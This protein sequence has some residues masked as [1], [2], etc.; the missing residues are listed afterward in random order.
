MV[1]EKRAHHI[2]EEAGAAI[3]GL[4]SNPQCVVERQHCTNDGRQL[5]SLLVCP[6]G[7]DIA[8]KTCITTCTI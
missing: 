4:L 2:R 5:H 8:R 7:G 6:W 1:S 3:G